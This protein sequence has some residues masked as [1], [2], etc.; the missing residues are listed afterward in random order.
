MGSPSYLTMRAVLFFSLVLV[1]SFTFGSTGKILEI[2]TK[3]STDSDSGMNGA[4]TVE[5]CDTGLNCCNAGN[6]DS[7]RDDFN[8]GHVD[9]FYG[10]MIR[11]CEGTELA[12]GAAILCRSQWNRWLEGRVDQDCTRGRKIPT[13]SHG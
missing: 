4:L 1:T 2:Q 6:I 9:V 8:K 13:M 10:G 7:D 12:D 5:I 3:T 11:Q